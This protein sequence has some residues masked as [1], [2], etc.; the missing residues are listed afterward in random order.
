V[1]GR[2][3]AV[4]GGRGGGSPAFAQGGGAQAGDLTATVFRIRQALGL[5]A[6]GLPAS[7]KIA[8]PVEP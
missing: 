8:R 3:L 4:T 7:P 6:T 2:V 1:L 5:G